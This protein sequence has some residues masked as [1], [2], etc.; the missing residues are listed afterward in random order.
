M[1]TFL[2]HAE[3]ILETAVIGSGEVAIVID[4]QGGLRLPDPAG[5]SLPA[6]RTEYG[7]AAVYKGERRGNSIRVEGWDGLRSCRI[8]TAPTSRRPTGKALPAVA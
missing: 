4:R 1:S 3:E 7:A 2:R 6:M 8:E 5:W